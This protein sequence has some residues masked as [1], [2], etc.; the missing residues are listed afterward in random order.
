MSTIEITF[1]SAWRL[2]TRIPTAVMLGLLSLYRIA[3]SPLLGPHC[4]FAPTCSAYATEAI[5]RHGTIRGG[6]MAL[7]RLLRCHPLHPGGW[8]PVAR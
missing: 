2:L 1:R 6:V 4:R 7:R 8:D 5:E 3:V